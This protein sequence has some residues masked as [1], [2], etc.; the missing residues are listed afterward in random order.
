[1]ADQPDLTRLGERL[2][3]V[4]AQLASLTQ[5]LGA[6][7]PVLHEASQ[8][9]IATCATCHARFDMLVHHYSIGLF[10][11]IVYVRCPSCNKE[12]PLQGGKD[13]Q[14]GLATG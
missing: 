5:A 11:N 9:Y 10:H 12:Q 2:S 14:V 3:A 13:G 4:E 1:M 6:L 8:R 7:T